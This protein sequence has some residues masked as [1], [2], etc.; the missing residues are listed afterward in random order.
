MSV[1]FLFEIY[2]KIQ[3]TEDDQRES[4]YSIISAKRYRFRRYDDTVSPILSYFS[5]KNL[6]CS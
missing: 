6:D 3:V 2:M 1:P 5:K 4:C